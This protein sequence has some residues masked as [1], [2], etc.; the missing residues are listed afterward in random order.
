MSDTIGILEK[1]LLDVDNF[2]RN[3]FKMTALNTNATNFL[4]I[5]KVYEGMFGVDKVKNFLIEE[6][7]EGE[8]LVQSIVKNR[9]SVKST[10]KALWD[11]MQEL[12]DV[13]TLRAVVTKRKK[14]GKTALRYS[15][16]MKTLDV[17]LPFL[18]GNKIE[19]Q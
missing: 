2:K 4:Y 6:N 3:V 16:E 17:F 14:M 11:Y 10:I 15:R 5:K 12:F 1:M 8:N 9:D 7:D 19:F 18:Q 13:E